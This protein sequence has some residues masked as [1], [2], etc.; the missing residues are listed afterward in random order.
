M[1]YEAYL[2]VKGEKQG[3]F[4]GESIKTARKDKWIAI[5][6]FSYEMISPRDAASGQASGKR[7]HKPI[8]IVKEWGAATPQLLSAL[9]TNESLP[10]VNF[11]FLKVDKQGKEFV[12]QTIKLGQATVCSV[13]QFTGGD[14]VGGEQM[15][16]KHTKETD[17]HECERVGF[18][19]MT[20]DVANQDA[21]TAWHDSWLD[22]A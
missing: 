12:Y 7:Q 11:E 8:K 1:A 13:Q 22:Q 5:L 21:K 6:A 20:I 3:Q 19:F 14:E 16:A 4:K 2:A 15:G 10:E 9:A 18:T 17:V